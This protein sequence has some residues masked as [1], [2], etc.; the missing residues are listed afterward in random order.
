MLNG[1]NVGGT[2]DAIQVNKFTMPGRNRRILKKD[3]DQAH[4][5]VG[6]AMP[7]SGI[8]VTDELNR[9][10]IQLKRS[11]DDILK[12]Y[13]ETDLSEEVRVASKL[14]LELVGHWRARKASA[15]KQV[16]TSLFDMLEAEDS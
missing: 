9:D 6:A 10:T 14:A 7:R 12:W 11:V 4:F 2:R 16:Q 8:N 5:L 15:S 1:K 13:A 3:L